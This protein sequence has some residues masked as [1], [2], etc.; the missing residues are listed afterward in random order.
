MQHGV[1][2]HE[3]ERSVGESQAVC[4]GAVKLDTPGSLPGRFQIGPRLRNH[5]GG[6]VDSHKLPELEAL[7]Q[8]QYDLSGTRAD[9]QGAPALSGAHQAKGMFDKC[10]V[11]AI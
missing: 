10:I 7:G 11:N 2:H 9:I 4:I 3:V 1:A 8:F 5:R 6:T